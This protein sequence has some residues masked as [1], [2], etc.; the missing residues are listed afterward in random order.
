MSAAHPPQPPKPT[1]AAAAAAD[2]DD[3]SDVGFALTP[4][5]SI[6]FT[7][8]TGEVLRAAGGVDGIIRITTL[9]YQR[10]HADAHIV[11]F[12]GAVQ[13]PLEVHARRLGMYIAEMMGSPGDPWT[14]DTRKNTTDRECPIQTASGRAIRVRDRMTAHYC[15]WNSV[16]R[17][18]DKIGRR[19]KLDDCRV[20]M[21]LF[22]WAVRD[23]GFDETSSLF[24]YLQK[25]VCFFIA[26]YE[27]TARPFALVESRW[28]ADEAR[29]EAY[30]RDGHFMGDVVDVP[31]RVAIQAVPQAERDLDDWLFRSARV[32]W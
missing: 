23:A 29:R 12:L 31:Y 11:Q 1:A 28:S 21:R 5:G 20:W 16:D 26:I 8:R 32:L 30:E 27:T 17:P 24:R 2:V 15:A 6:A 13:Q 9:F 4:S 14:T 7:E 3:G 22:F 25:F 10:F 18:R 19:F